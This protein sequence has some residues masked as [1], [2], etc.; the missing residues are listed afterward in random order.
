MSI[1]ALKVFEIAGDGM[2]AQ[3]TRMDTVSEN[4]ANAETTRTETGGP[5]R[6]KRVVFDA[7]FQGMSFQ[8]ELRSAELGMRR[9]REGHAA[10]L[11]AGSPRAGLDE[12]NIM[13]ITQVD[14]NAPPR[15][16]FDPSHPDANEDGYVE[17]PDV[18]IVTEM[19]DL[20]SATRAYEANLTT[21]DAAKAMVAKALEI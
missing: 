1:G 20:M 15:M 11:P 16:I 8:R 13:A 14:P 4:I 19:V 12:P 10:T 21:I 17:V 9:T 3:R 5:Y 18:D 2:S 6:R 7:P